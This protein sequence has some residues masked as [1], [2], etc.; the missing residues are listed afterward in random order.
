MYKVVSG[1]FT[2]DGWW[3]ME[4]R[5]KVIVQNGG[6]AQARLKNQP[7]RDVLA[8]YTCGCLDC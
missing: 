1:M 7:G 4:W 8:K 2:L 3:S 6:R 5:V